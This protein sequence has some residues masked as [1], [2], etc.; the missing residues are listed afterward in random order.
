MNMFILGLMKHHSES[1]TEVVQNMENIHGLHKFKFKI[2]K[3][4]MSI[5][6]E[7]QF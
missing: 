5:T 4:N 3:E 1:S 6:A 7:E 2:S